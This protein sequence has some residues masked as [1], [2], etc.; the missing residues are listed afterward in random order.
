[1]KNGKIVQYMM[2]LT[3]LTIF[4]LLSVEEDQFLVATREGFNY[5]VNK[6]PQDAPQKEKPSPYDT[7][8]ATSDGTIV[9]IFDVDRFF[10]QTLGQS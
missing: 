9:R 1:M 3:F 6:R 2:H 7:L 10:H 8:V 4:L 5:K